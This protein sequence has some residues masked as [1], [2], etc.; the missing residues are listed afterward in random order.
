MIY[1]SFGLFLALAAVIIAWITLRWST[2]RL[3]PGPAEDKRR[4]RYRW[5]LRATEVA[6]S[7][8]LLIIAGIWFGWYLRGKRTV[9]PPPI[10]V[11]TPAP[12]VEEE[13]RRVVRESQMFEYL[14]L[15]R[16]PETPQAD[17]LKR[18]W[19]PTA[20]G[21]REIIKVEESLDR[22][23]RQGWR[24]GKESKAEQ[25]AV[26]SVRLTGNDTASVETTERWFLPLYDKS[27]RRVPGKNSFFGPYDVTYLLRRVDGRWL[28]VDSTTPRA[29]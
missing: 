28:I 21:G 16:S 15:Y 17:F 19:L 14:S 18:F 1:A 29:K 5:W 11:A 20:A 3:P 4:D 6:M 10:D 12:A 22:M 8:I 24:Y 23:T 7:I 9:V 25:F 26:R 2:G 27:G 13:L